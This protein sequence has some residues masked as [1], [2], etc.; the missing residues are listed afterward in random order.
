MSITK[1]ADKNEFLTEYKEYK[2]LDIVIKFCFIKYKN[3]IIIDN[4]KDCIE[5]FTIEVYINIIKY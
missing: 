2:I 5:K 1:L 3:V 4:N